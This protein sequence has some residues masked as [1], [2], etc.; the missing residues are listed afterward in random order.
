MGPHLT[1][2]VSFN[3]IEKLLTSCPHCKIPFME[4]LI[5]TYYP[6]SQSYEK[7]GSSDDRIPGTWLCVGP[8]Y[9]E[10]LAHRKAQNGCGGQHTRCI[11]FSSNGGHPPPT[12]RTASFFFCNPGCLKAT[13]SGLKQSRSNLKLDLSRAVRAGEETQLIAS[14]SYCLATALLL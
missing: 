3:P 9:Y 1:Q 2:N 4:A 7:R 6:V 12:R 8:H 10:P 13:W 11:T 5:S 14:R